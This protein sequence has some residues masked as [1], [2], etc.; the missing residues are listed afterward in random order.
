VEGDTGVIEGTRCL[1]C[2]GGPSQLMLKDPNYS[3]LFERTQA[4]TM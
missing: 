1:G 2:E 3:Q 4:A